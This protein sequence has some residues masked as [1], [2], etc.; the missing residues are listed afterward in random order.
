MSGLHRRNKMKITR[1]Q[2]KQIIKEELEASIREAHGLSKKDAE[3]L[4]AFAK[5]QEGEIKWIL[6]FLITSNVEVN[7]TQDVTKMKKGD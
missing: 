3:T 4:K 6:D 5:G 2:L 7:R 1:E